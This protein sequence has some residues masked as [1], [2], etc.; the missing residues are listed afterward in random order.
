MLIIQV[1]TMI[2]LI[3]ALHNHVRQHSKEYAHSHAIIY[4]FNAKIHDNGHK[5]KLLVIPL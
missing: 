3:N 1:V 2:L 4:K 5:M